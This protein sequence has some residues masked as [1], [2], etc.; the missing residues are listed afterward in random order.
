MQKV[1]NE[2][3]EYTDV[4]VDGRRVRTMSSGLVI[5]DLEMSKNTMIKVAAPANDVSISYTGQLKSN[6]F[7]FVSNV[8]RYHHRFS[9]GMRVGDKRRLTIPPSMGAYTCSRRLVSKFL[10]LVSKF[11]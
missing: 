6:G 10:S 11:V 2:E 4:I 9:L 1:K 7:I 8:G 3:I 5:E